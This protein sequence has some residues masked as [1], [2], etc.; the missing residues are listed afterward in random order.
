VFLQ[1]YER[2]VA[3]IE[4]L[5]D[6]VSFYQGTSRVFETPVLAVTDGLDS[7]C[8]AKDWELEP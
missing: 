1:A 7:I 4:P 6:L 3:A 2:G 8:R 5:A